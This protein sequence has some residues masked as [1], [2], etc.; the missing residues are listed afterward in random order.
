MWTKKIFNEGNQ[1][2]NFMC[3]SGSGTVINYGSGSNSD[4]LTSSGS[5]SGSGSTSQKVTV[6]TVPVPVP[7]HWW[8]VQLSLAACKHPISGEGC[9]YEGCSG[10]GYNCES[11]SGSSKGWSKDDHGWR[12]CEQLGHR[13]HRI[14]GQVSQRNC[15]GQA[16]RGLWYGNFFLNGFIYLFAIDSFVAVSRGAVR[17]Y[18]HK[19]SFL[20]LTRKNWLF[21]SW[22]NVHNRH[23][24]RHRHR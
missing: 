24:H 16:H 15:E 8:N 4:F 3:S 10:K 18:Q 17:I 11:Y 1:I 5:G 21:F 22:Y 6:P 2:H 13:V 9:T 14:Q 7:Q 20:L 19:L 12:D 23:R